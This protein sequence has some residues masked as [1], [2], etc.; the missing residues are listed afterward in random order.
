MQAHSIEPPPNIDPETPPRA[1]PE[2]AAVLLEGGLSVAP[3]LIEGLAA[4]PPDVVVHDSFAIWGRL[5]AE[6]IGAPR[7]CST[8]TF[9]LTRSGVPLRALPSLLTSK[10]FDPRALRRLRNARREVR[11]RFG[12]DPGGTLAT[13][14]SAAPTTIV[15]TSRGLQPGAGRL[16]QRFNFVGPMLD[17]LEAGVEPA[18]A[19]LPAGRPLVYLSLGTLRNDRA[20][21][22]RACVAAV[23]DL[24]VSLLISIGR[25]VEPA[26]LGPLPPN[27]VVR[28]H[29][30]QFAVLAQAS[31]FIT[32]AGM[33][34]AHEAL[35]HGVPMLCLPQADDQFLVAA[36]LSK[37]GA[38]RVGRAT[39]TRLRS[40]V[41]RILRDG[42]MRTAAAA[43]GAD[44]GA[45]GGAAAAKSLV[46]AAAGGRAGPGG[47][48]PGLGRS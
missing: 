7:V 23:A 10:A 11:R 12:A 40:D 33:N 9:A 6:A 1:L 5:A 4:D 27:V 38:A 41:E 22:Y 8:S 13:L 21:I 26:A 16:D 17:P 47:A 44:L 25:R 28:P 3:E 32:H 35:V 46:L 20:D 34:S 2:L 14:A 48:E 43:L 30:D 24:P 45:A 15:F 37:L 18:L 42:R 39:V 31:V 19:E 29:V 36:R